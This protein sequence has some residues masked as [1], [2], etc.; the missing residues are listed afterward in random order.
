MKYRLLGNTGVWVSEIS[1]GAMTFGGENHP[2][3]G[4]LGALGREDADR[5]VAAALD[6]GVNLIDTA[7]VY[8]DGE[9]EELLGHALRRRRDDVVLATK[10]HAPTGPGPNDAGWSRLHVMQALDASLRRL[11]T[12]H[13][14][15]Y[16]LHNFDPLTPFEEV[17]AALD[18]AVR[19]GK[20][21]YI[22]C[23]NL[24]AWQVSR[25]LGVSAARNLNRFVSVQAYYSLVGRDAERDLVPMAQAE[26]VGLL[27][28]S[29]L[30]GG[31][32]TGK[33]KREGAS[34]EVGRR[35]TDG[36][37]DFPPVD[38]ERGHDVV[39]VLRAVAA[40]HGV[41]VSRTAVAWLL[42]QPAVTSVT[43]GA[44]KIEQLTDNIGASGL[45]LTEQD[46]A[47][48]DEVSKLPPAYPNWIQ[49]AFASARQPN[50]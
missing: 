40:R 8:S 41:S 38:R 18:D 14:D 27:V 7:D 11:G 39:D 26:G 21:R 42:A 3:Y 10:V 44:R 15:L 31:F 2:V 45:V 48:L 13:I 43:V 20:V 25:A 37:I 30:A 24:A 47:D 49:A 12:D 32:L 33:V 16:Q 17:L 5:M 4:S 23:S 35:N 34:T 28:W 29:P 6:A 9:S 36:H 50:G 46:L 19:Q 1:L 22:G